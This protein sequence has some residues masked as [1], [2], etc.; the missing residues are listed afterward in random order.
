MH[1][2]T[3]KDT[4][5]LNL[6]YKHK[7]CKAEDLLYFPKYVQI[8]T[9]ALC[10]ARCSMCPANE[11]TRDTYMMEDA[12]F[13]KIAKELQSYSDWIKKVT[14]QLDGEPLLDKKLENRI[15]ALK[16]IGISCVAFSTNASLLSEKRARSI[17]DSGVD[18]VSFSVDGATAET[19]EKIRRGLS[20]EK[21]RTNLHKFIKLR[22]M[23]SADTSIRVRMT[24]QKANV[25]EYYDFVRYWHNYLKP[26]DSVYG[27]L[28]HSWGN[29]LKRYSLAK[30]RNKSEINK[31]PCVSPWNSLVVL[32]DGKVPLCC[33]DFRVILL[34]GDANKKSIK[35][36]WNCQEFNKIRNMHEKYGRASIEMCRNCN[37]WDPSTKIY[38]D[39]SI[40]VDFFE[41]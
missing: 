17:I 33:E 20:F 7:L 26:S 10:N 8:E 30:N 36:I 9:V 27:K 21:C 22:N 29:W 39:G 11:W 31:S 19:F 15:T 24:I 14:I 38:S 34:M 37:I 3:K 40:F 18:E 5:L 35:D 41:D 23:L 32:S 12:L 6:A 25:H 28:I 4:E 16:E 1:V 13:D 2:T